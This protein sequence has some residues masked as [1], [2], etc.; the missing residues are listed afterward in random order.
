MW[1]INYQTADG[2][3]QETSNFE[4]PHH[5]PMQGRNIDNVTINISLTA[6]VLIA[7]DK[8]APLLTGNVKKY[9]STSRHRAM[10]YLERNL[11]RIY[12]P[13]ELSITAYALAR[14]RSA[15][16]D[17]AYGRLLSLKRE[18]AGMIYWSRTKITT[19]RV[20]YEFNRPFLEAKDRQL[21]DAPAVEATS[22]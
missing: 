6:H 3:F 15:E 1:L 4:T 16:A 20:R 21:N 22:Y 9:C 13:Y 7:L 14:S 10:K 18:E 17:T 2:A 5:F 12:D 11:A 8:V 19:N